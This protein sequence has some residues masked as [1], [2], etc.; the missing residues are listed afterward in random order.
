V[1]CRAGGEEAGE[2]DCEGR[3]REERVE[4][5][6]GESRGVIGK[7]NLRASVL[8]ESNGPLMYVPSFFFF[9]ETKALLPCRSARSNAVFFSLSICLFL[10]LSFLVSRGSRRDGDGERVRV[11]P[12][13]SSRGRS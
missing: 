2:G 3:G 10:S 4:E 11:V 6:R 1:A 9:P 8:S 5:T 12:Y 7:H 13:D